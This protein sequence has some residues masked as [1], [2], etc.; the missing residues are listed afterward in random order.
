MAPSNPE[1]DQSESS[2]EAFLAQ[3]AYHADEDA[4]QLAPVQDELTLARSPV[5]GRRRFKQLFNHFMF[6]KRPSQYSS[7]SPRLPDGTRSKIFPFN[8]N[9]RGR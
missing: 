6:E 9:G 3:P 5:R 1:N 8:G 2:V 7:I 4:A